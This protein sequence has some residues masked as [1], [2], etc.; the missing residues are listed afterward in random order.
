MKVL[1]EYILLAA[2]IL[3]YSCQ[4]PS[5]AVLPPV[6]GRSGE[7]LVVADKECWENHAGALIR[8]MMSTPYPQLPQFEPVFDIVPIPE[9]SFTDF[10][11]QHRNVMIAE[12]SE[13]YQEA[14]MVIER[15]RYADSQIIVRLRAAD[16]SSMTR[17]LE[18]NRD[19]I[20]MLFEVAE[21]NRITAANRAH[22]DINLSDKVRARHGISL[23]IPEGYNIAGED[24]LLTWL[25][26]ETGAVITG[27]VI[28]EYPYTGT[29]VLNLSSLVTRRDMMVR[30]IHGEVPGSYMATEKEFSPEIRDL[31]LHGQQPVT[32]MRGLWRM[33]NG[34]SMGGPFIGVSMVDTSRDR[35]VT[36]E[37][38]VFAAGQKKREY[39]RQVGAIVY[40]LSGEGR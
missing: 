26:Q 40:S 9:S 11:L 23:I 28:Y 30:L 16:D 34:I 33:E 39:M 4:T 37:G 19:S 29:G 6:S 20:L 36:A 12:V 21:I 8:Q 35:I 32:E 27:I 10:L 17:L 7:V 25:K 5:T 15:D 14:S 3:Q 18:A 31:M 13:N 1:Q 2:V 24:S 38:F 22:R